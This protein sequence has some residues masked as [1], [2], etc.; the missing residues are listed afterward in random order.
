MKYLILGATT[1]LSGIVLFGM[2]WM[3]VAVY[4]SRGG[5]YENFSA[6]MS[7]IGYFPIFI[8]I[9]LVFTGKFFCNVL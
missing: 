8:S 2:T 9:I 5:V 4:S 1:F 6:A 7:A 3:A